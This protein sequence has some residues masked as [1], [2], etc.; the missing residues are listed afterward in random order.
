MSLVF[1]ALISFGEYGGVFSTYFDAVYSV[2]HNDFIKAQP[3]YEGLK[4]SV[5]KYPEVDGMHRTFYHITHQGEDE[6]NRQPDVRRME[7]IR[8]P[9]FVIENFEHEEILI[10]KN[11]RG[12]DERIVLFNEIENYIVNLTDR[13]EYYMFITAYYIET[14]H[15]KRKLLKEYETYIKAKTA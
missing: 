6:A 14:E 12:K 1:P 5:R 9:K 13:G 15:R 8:F 10:W 2:F 7:R 3:I 11:V 4:V